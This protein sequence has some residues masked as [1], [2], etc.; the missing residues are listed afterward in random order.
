[1]AVRALRHAIVGACLSVAATAWSEPPAAAAPVATAESTG[2]DEPSLDS[3]TVA[4]I[5]REVEIGTALAEEDA[6]SQPAK[7]KA[8]VAQHRA[9][10][11]PGAAASTPESVESPYSLRGRSKAAWEWVKETLPW[12]EQKDEAEAPREPVVYDPL[13]VTGSPFDTTLGARGAGGVGFGGGLGATGSGAYGA[14][15][16]AP[17][18]SPDASAD[19]VMALIRDAVRIVEEAVAHPMTWLVIALFVIGGFAMK[20]FDRRPK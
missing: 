3:A 5:I 1:M 9:G 19:N 4:E 14:V 7:K 16:A 10:P 12:L 13:G 2:A 8:P 18:G 6:A 15:P 17:G 20:R 11:K